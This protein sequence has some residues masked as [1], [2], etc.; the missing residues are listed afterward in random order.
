MNVKDAI[1]LAVV[2][3]PTEFL[4]VSPKKALP[5]TRRHLIHDRRRWF[6]LIKERRGKFPVSSRAQFR[7]SSRG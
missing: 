7:P 1:T 5:L 2:Q 6:D 3:G 4:P